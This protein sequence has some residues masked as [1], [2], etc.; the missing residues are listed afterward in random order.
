MSRSHKFDDCATCRFRRRRD[1]CNECDAGEQ[2][3]DASIGPLRFDD[4]AV[5]SRSTQSLVTDDDEP[6]MNPDDLIERLERETD[7]EAETNDE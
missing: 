2:Y 6:D 1:I 3:E 4:E 7:K 5:I